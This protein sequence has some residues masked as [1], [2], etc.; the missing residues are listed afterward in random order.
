MCISSASPM[1]TAG[2]RSDPAAVQRHAAL[3]C[4]HTTRGGKASTLPGCVA[5]HCCQLMAG[6]LVEKRLHPTHHLLSLPCCLLPAAGKASWKVKPRTAA[7]HVPTAVLLRSSPTTLCCRRSQTVPGA[8]IQVGQGGRQRQLG[9]GCGSAADHGFTAANLPPAPCNSRSLL[10]GTFASS[11]A[12]A[13]KAGG[14]ASWE[15]L[16]LRQ[17]VASGPHLWALPLTSL[18]LHPKELKTRGKEC[19]GLPKREATRP[20]RSY[21]RHKGQQAQGRWV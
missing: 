3:C 4:M 11:R 1:L 19:D 10:R 8:S 17:W 13:N 9:G 5:G 15:A 16:G 20:T 2:G 12:A 18:Q 14:A 6:R 21:A 7:Y